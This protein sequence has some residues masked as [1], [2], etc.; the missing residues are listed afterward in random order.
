MQPHVKNY[1][2]SLNLSTADFIACEVCGGKAVE[3]HH[4]VFRSKFGKKR[5]DEQDAPAN[6][7]ALCRG[8]HIQAHDNILKPKFLKSIA[9]K[10]WTET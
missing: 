1:L 6:L 2:E 5:K 3:V 9:N 7:I 8:C 10:R 4:I